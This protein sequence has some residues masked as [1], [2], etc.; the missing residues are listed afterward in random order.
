[1]SEYYTLEPDDQCAELVARWEG[2]EAKA[3]K[4][5]V[6]VVTI[7]YGST[8]WFNRPG[9]PIVRMGETITRQEALE[10]LEYELKAKWDRVK[11]SIEI[12]LMQK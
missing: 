3:Y 9:Q 1:M 4:D 5:I 8:R 2:F 11:D 6:G 7:G 12:D 10:L